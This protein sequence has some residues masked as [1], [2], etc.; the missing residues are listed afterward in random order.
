MGRVPTEEQRQHAQR[1]AERQT[2]HMTRLLDDLLDVSR[3]S[4]GRVELKKRRVELRSLLHQSVDAV[5]SHL[6]AKE[7]TL[8]VHLADE[9]LWLDADPVRI[10]QIVT[11]LL[12]NA[13]KY[14]DPG[15]TIDL[16]SERDGAMA[17][18]RVRD[19]G[20]GFDA[21]MKP[22][23]F[24]LFSQAEGVGQRAAGGLGIGLALVREFAERHGGSVEAASDGPLLG[25]EFVVRLP[26]TVGGAIGEASSR[27]E[28]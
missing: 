18:I 25:S 2:E 22:R 14:T 4:N 9:D 19:N 17:V 5:R 13:A 26:C 12:N 1:I 23:L 7:H 3:I 21:Q 20:I 16:V 27:R 28:G 8:R 6:Q 15:G 24:T 11:N 10:Q